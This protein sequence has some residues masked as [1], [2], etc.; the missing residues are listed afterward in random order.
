ML[1]GNTCRGSTTSVICTIC[2][3]ETKTDAANNIPAWW[4]W[5]TLEKHTR[6]MNVNVS[7][8][9]CWTVIVKILTVVYHLPKKPGN[10]KWNV[11]LSPRRGIFSRINGFLERKTK[12]PKRNFRVETVRLIC[13][14]LIVPGLLNWIVFDPVFSEKVE[15]KRDHSSLNVH[16]AFDASHLLQL[17]INFVPISSFAPIV[18]CIPLCQT[19]R[20]ETSWNSHHILRSHRANRELNDP[21]LFLFLNLVRVSSISVI[22]EIYWRKAGN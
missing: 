15:M 20:S 12:G 8:N 19:E 21:Y 22:A 14:F 5:E 1:Y 6:L 2:I 7:P 9:V 10:F 17:S 11:V 16:S 4:N 18:G 13:W 3:L